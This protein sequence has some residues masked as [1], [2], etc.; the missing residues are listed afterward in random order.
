MLSH[1]AQPVIASKQSLLLLCWR[2]ILPL[3]LFDQRIIN[4]PSFAKL[5]PTAG[6]SSRKIVGMPPIRRLIRKPMRPRCSNV[7]PK[8]QSIT[9]LVHANRNLRAPWSYWKERARARRPAGSEEFREG[10]IR[11]GLSRYRGFWN[12]SICRRS[13][14]KWIRFLNQGKVIWEAIETIPKLMISF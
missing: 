6:S 11:E 1:L 7:F 8:E 2:E 4:E 9:I 14:S 13:K 3:M 10:W 5:A 12:R